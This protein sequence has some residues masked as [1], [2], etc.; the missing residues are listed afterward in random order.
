MVA[1]RRQGTGGWGAV[2]GFLG[3][4]LGEAHRR[5]GRTVRKQKSASATLVCFVP[6]IEQMV[7]VAYV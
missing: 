4:I 1:V 2:R 3:A 5:A 6:Q 7:D